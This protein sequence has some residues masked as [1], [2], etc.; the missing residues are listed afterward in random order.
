MSTRRGTSATVTIGDVLI[1]L[2]ALAPA[3]LLLMA[4]G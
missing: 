4:R 1:V 3:I 2:L